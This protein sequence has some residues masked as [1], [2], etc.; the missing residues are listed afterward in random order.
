MD[1]ATLTTQVLM[2]TPTAA[3]STGSPGEVTRDTLGY[4][5]SGTPS[6]SPEHTD[7]KSEG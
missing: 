2:S 4:T 5:P 3:D 6:S 1:G 7:S